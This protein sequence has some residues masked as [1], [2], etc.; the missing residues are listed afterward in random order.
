MWI[1]GIG[2]DSDNTRLFVTCR[3]T[4]DVRIEMGTEGAVAWMKDVPNEGVAES[5]S[6]CLVGSGEACK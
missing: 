6:R 2:A 1:D 5:L 3:Q 4:L